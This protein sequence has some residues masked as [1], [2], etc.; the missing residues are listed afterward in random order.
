MW[1]YLHG[2]DV[3]V[4]EGQKFPATQASWGRLA[5]ALREEMPEEKRGILRCGVVIRV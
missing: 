3:L 1:T 4:H 2:R 5:D